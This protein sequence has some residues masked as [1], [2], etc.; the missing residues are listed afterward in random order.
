MQVLDGRIY[1]ICG[2]VAALEQIFCGRPYGWHPISLQDIRWHIQDESKTGDRDT[3]V[4]VI[5][6][7]W[8]PDE[9]ISIR[10]CKQAGGWRAFEGA[11]SRAAWWGKSGD[12]LFKVYIDF[13]IEGR[14]QTVEEFCRIVSA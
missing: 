11:V 3:Y 5:P 8:S 6:A 4:T 2:V 9:F 1:A 14:F 10:L 7:E 13:R 12:F